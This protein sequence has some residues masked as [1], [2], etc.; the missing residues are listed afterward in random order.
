MLGRKGLTQ[1]PY[2][3]DRDRP[4]YFVAPVIDGNARFAGVDTTA[5]RCGR[6]GRPRDHKVHLRPPGEE[7]MDEQ[8]AAAG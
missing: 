3:T 7:S 8:Q 1:A 4:H 6:C 2:V 5:Q